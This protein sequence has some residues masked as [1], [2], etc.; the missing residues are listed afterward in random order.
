MSTGTLDRIPLS[1]V[2]VG[3][4]EEELVLSVLRSG[5]LT[6]GP[7][8][9]RLEDVMAR[10]AGT[11]HAVA[12]SNGTIALVAALQA[13]GVGP[14]DEVVTSPLTFGATL[15]AILHVGAT[16][17]FVDVA[18][19][20]TM[21]PGALARALERPPASSGTPG[22]RVPRRVVLPVHLYGYPADMGAITRVA[23]A[24][25]AK[26]LEDAAQAVGAQVDGQ[27]VGSF[28]VGC[29]SLY[30]TKN[31]TTGEGGMVTTDDAEVA[32]RI[33]LLRGQGMRERYAYEIVGHNYRMT[34]IQAAI[35]VPQ[36][37][38]LAQIIGERQ[39]NAAA[40]SE[41][42]RGLP[43]IVVPAPAAGR[44][45]VF[46][47]YAIRVTP[48]CPVSRAELMDHLNRL[49][50]DSAPVY[51]RLVF[52]YACYRDHPQ[53]STAFC[54]VADALT[55]EVLCLPVR[56]GLSDEDLGRIVDAVRG[57]VLGERL[58][59]RPLHG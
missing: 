41:G 59:L 3:P 22:G 40:L 35:G 39:A 23:E 52:D 24:A 31:V 49:G 21:D 1:T 20:F 2:I 11:A 38:R 17:S 15:N 57:A 51:P 48:E 14:G 13:L 4:E 37:G 47:L 16:A 26:I 27:P 32:D 29:F 45:H 7:M 53:V 58:R 54:P 19:D 12:V 55:S 50:I 56:P 33:R 5:R 18:E 28:G 25:G 9:A 43:G 44:E 6:Q 34:D 30:A 46:H 8:V 42:L 10:V 36:L